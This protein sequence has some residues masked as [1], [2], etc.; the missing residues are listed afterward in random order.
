MGVKKQGVGKYRKER[1][2]GVKWGSFGRLKK[3]VKKSKDLC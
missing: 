1:I 2:K 3:K